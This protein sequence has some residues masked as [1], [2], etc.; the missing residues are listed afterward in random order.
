[1]PSDP[2]P[3]EAPLTLCYACKP[4][5]TC[6][7][8]R[9]MVALSL[10]DPRSESP[11]PEA[12]E[13]AVARCWQACREYAQRQPD[14]TFGHDFGVF[15]MQQ[16]RDLLDNLLAAARRAPCGACGLT[17]EKVEGWKDRLATCGAM[18]LPGPRY[19]MLG[20]V[21]DEMWDALAPVAP[22]A[23]GAA[24]AGAGMR[25]EITGHPCGTD[26]VMVGGSPDCQTCA[27]WLQRHAGDAGPAGRSA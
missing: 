21:L 8:H 24:D 23:R 14:I 5:R 17:R 22:P 26:T 16:F 10:R 11:S 27:L 4:G 18:S 13:A 3:P 1:M 19:V 15:C 2:T 7:A 20:K 6:K 25:C 9:G 12:L